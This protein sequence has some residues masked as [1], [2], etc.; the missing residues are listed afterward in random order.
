[1]CV[2]NSTTGMSMNEWCEWCECACAYLLHRTADGRQRVVGGVREEPAGGK[3]KTGAS[4]VQRTNMTAA[5]Q[6]TVTGENIVQCL[7]PPSGGMYGP[8]PFYVTTT[9]ACAYPPYSPPLLSFSSTPLLPIT[10]SY[11]IY[12]FSAIFSSF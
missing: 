9:S 12:S 5:A 2:F 11:T 7:S 10:F 8:V 3:K 6:A 4:E 1:M